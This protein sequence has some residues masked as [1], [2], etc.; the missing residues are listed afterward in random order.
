MADLS[1]QRWRRFGHDRVYVNDAG[2][3]CLGWLDRTTDALVLED[4]TRREAVLEILARHGHRHT[5]AEDPAV[6]ARHAVPVRTFAARLP[7]VHTDERA[8]HVGARDE[9][10]AGACLERLSDEWRVLH[11]VPV[12]DRDADIDHLVV[13]PGGVFTINAK[14]HPDANV[15]VAGNTFMVN[16]RR[17]PYVRNA[18]HEARRAS[19]ALS[20]ATEQRIE[21]TGVIAVVGAAGGFTVREQPADVRVEARKRLDR[22]LLAQPVQLTDAD[23]ERAHHAARRSDTW[24]PR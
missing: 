22:W 6:A 7:G 24:Q 9:E 19:R 23:V 5:T 14:H 20:A 18:R 15:W 10:K 8:W 3:A 4:T 12:G 2:G 13:G 17:Q 1:V 11:A 21:V 16:G